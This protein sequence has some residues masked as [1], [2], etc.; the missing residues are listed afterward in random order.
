MMATTNTKKKATA[1]ASKEVSNTAQETNTKVK[2]QPFPEKDEFSA[3]LIKQ[4]NKDAGSKIA[5]NLGSD[6]AAPT[7]I[8]R[9]ISTGSVQLNYIIRNDKNGGIPEGRI[10]EIQGPPSCHA[11][12]TK[13]LRYDGSVINVE[14]VKPGMLLMGPNS[15]PRKV[16]E[17][18]SGVDE[19]YQ[20]TPYSGAEPFVVN[21][22]HVL[23][24]KRSA[25]KKKTRHLVGNVQNITVRD[26]L[27]TS[28]TFKREHKLYRSKVV[29]FPQCNNQEFVIPPYIM[30]LLLGDGSLSSK[31]IE[32]TTA[33]KEIEREFTTYVSSLGHSVGYHRTEGRKAYG[34]YVN[35]NNK[36]TNIIA[37]NL[38][39]FGLL[40]TDSGNKF[41]PEHYKLASPEDR[42][43]LL[44]GLI[45]TDGYRGV[46]GSYEYTTKSTQLGEDVA[47]LA[48]SLGMA[49]TT[50]QKSIDGKVYQRLYIFGD[51]KRLPSRLERKQ[52]RTTNVLKNMHQTG[53]N[54]EHVGP[55][56]FYGF[57][58]D[59]DN[60]FLGHDFIVHHNSGKTHIAYEMCKATQAMNGV[61]VYIDAENA[62]SLENL[63]SV[64][65]D[66]CHRFVFIQETCIEE[67][68]KVI[69]STILK[70]RNMKRDVPVLVVWDSVAAS[71][72][73]AELEGDY[74]QNTI[75]LAARVLSKGFRKITHTIG[76]MN[77]A[78]VLINQQR[79]KVG[80]MYGDPT[81]T[82]GGM[83][84]PYHSSVRLKLT[85]GQ[86]IK[87]TINGKEAVV[88]INVSVKTIKNKVARPWREVDFEI[89][90]G[91]GIRE[92]E[93]LFDALREF[94]D[95]S[96]NQ[97]VVN[98]K[99]VKVHGT[100]A[101]KTFEVSDNTTGEI[102]VEEKF[103]K[104]DFAAKI[105]NNPAYKEY[106]QA[107]LDSCFIMRSDDDSH[108]TAASIDTNSAVEVEAAN[109]Q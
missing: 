43:Q 29:S 61:V 74:D 51:M 32:L 52:P 31:R 10:I 2:P 23:S 7:I 98:G 97:V 90:F 19:M 50:S 8:K 100:Q 4:I 102:L 54:I 53:F 49:V 85:G 87:K 83:A 81:T 46:N 64:G 80:V 82:P 99:R 3:E 15:Q 91:K 106:V 13:V 70:A 67:I 78:L 96:K 94:C 12:G 34:L 42:L 63:I 84:I 30:G 28:T 101:W 77:V 14:D 68:F 60:L 11:K 65:I 26:Y 45:D 21:Q 48:R 86:Q 103:Y 109:M 57:S 47:F 39:A 73:K 104:P 18:H 1:T 16:L 62:T 76:D 58:V 22:H 5:F 24:L 56:E 37:E 36:P 107:L 92:Q 44:A 95:N 41:I 33:D 75:G 25:R 6:A 35:K 89:H 66:V 59:A 69:E 72:P 27:Q 79:T 20:I 38:K 105:L 17:T 40:D 88:G 9:W 71:V 108:I 55:G 93:Q